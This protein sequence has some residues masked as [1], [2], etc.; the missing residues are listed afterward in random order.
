MRTTTFGKNLSFIFRLSRFNSSIERKSLGANRKIK[1]RGFRKLIGH[2]I[3]AICRGAV[4]RGISDR[5]VLNHIS[6]Y[7]YGISFATSFV[8]GEHLAKYKVEDSDFPGNYRVFQMQ[9]YLKRVGAILEN[10]KHILIWLVIL[11]FRVKALPI[12]SHRL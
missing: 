3:S 9:W 5:T 6:R 7:N 1:D 12:K 8:E 2:S 11:K 10:H 4:V